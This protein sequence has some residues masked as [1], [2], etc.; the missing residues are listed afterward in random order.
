MVD[1]ETV[2]TPV[3]RAIETNA[4]YFGVSL[5]QLMETA[6]RNI[7]EEIAVQEETEETAL[8]LP[9]TSHASASRSKLYWQEKP[10]TSFIHQHKRTGLPSS[11]SKTLF[12]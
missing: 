10:K 9:A 5:L 3:M 8:L 7:A 11:P 1:T 6:G 2:S 4:E 12:Y